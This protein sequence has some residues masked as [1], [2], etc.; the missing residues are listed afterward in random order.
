MYVFYNT[1]TSR[2]PTN[3]KKNFRGPFLPC[4]LRSSFLLLSLPPYQA[5][6]FKRTRRQTCRRFVTRVSISQ[7]GAVMRGSAKKLNPSKTFGSERSVGLCRRDVFL[8]PCV[9]CRPK[10]NLNLFPW[11]L[12]GDQAHKNMGVKEKPLSLPPLQRPRPFAWARIGHRKGRKK[13]RSQFGR[14]SHR[15]GFS[16]PDF[17]FFARPTCTG[18]HFVL[19]PCFDMDG[20]GR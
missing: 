16:P 13:W 12:G 20:R 10:S 1:P 17:S 14:A 15:Q 3:P 19:T 9:F 5:I 8:S 7:I 11:R 4:R 18:F 2:Q 6:S